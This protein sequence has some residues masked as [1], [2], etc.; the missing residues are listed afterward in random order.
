MIGR[1]RNQRLEIYGTRTSHGLRRLISESNR[2]LGCLIDFKW[3]MKANSDHH[4]F[5]AEQIPA[6]MF[7]TGLHDDYHRPSDDAHLVNTTGM[8]LSARLLFHVAHEV[9]ERKQLEGFRVSSQR[10]STV[11]RRQI[12]QPL[13]ALP[14]RLGVRWNNQSVEGGL[15]VLDVESGSPADLAGVRVGDRI[16]RFDSEKP[17]SGDQFRR[18][19]L[20][21][22]SPVTIE[23]LR[24]GASEPIDLTVQLRGK[25]TRVGIWVTSQQRTR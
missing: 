5:F 11:D 1:M 19:M 9:A 3:E 2:D 25:Q 21:A 6:L 17:A 20:T 10:E 14:A 8:Q 15:L 23:I 13:A 4:P 22:A 16:I 12:E 18:A 24:G 7:H